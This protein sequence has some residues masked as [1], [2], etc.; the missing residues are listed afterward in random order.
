MNFIGLC[1]RRWPEEPLMT[2]SQGKSPECKAKPLLWARRVPLSV[3]LTDL[4]KAI[5]INGLTL[6]RGDYHGNGPRPDLPYDIALMPSS[7][8]SLMN[9]S[10]L[11]VA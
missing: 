8:H 2:A 5:P 1:G 9:S 7:K 6:S 3:A 4:Q 11:T 10:H